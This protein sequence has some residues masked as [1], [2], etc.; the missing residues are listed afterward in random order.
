MFSIFFQ[1]VANVN[2]ELRATHVS[3]INKLLTFTKT[4]HLCS[5]YMCL[6]FSFARVGYV[7]FHSIETNNTNMWASPAYFV[8]HIYKRYHLSQKKQAALTEIPSLEARHFKYQKSSSC[9]T[10]KGAMFYL[11]FFFQ[12]G[13]YLDH[14]MFN[15][16]RSL[17]FITKYYCS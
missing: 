2:V 3:L 17:Q 10:I 8:T 5:F 11:F 4:Q 6:L 13:F 14:D 16:V 1:F 9:D 12:S 7:D 15:S